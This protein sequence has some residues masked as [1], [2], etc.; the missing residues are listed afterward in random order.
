MTSLNKKKICFITG[1]RAEYGLIERMVEL[2]S[3]NN[4]FRTYLIVTG[5]HLSKKFGSTIK[6]ISKANINLKKIPIDLNLDSKK[7][8]YLNQKKL[9][10][11]IYKLS[12]KIKPTCFVVLGDRFE[13]FSLCSFIQFLNIPIVHIHGGEKTSGSLDDQLRHCITKMSHIH[14]VANKEFK[15][16]VLQL[17]EAKS[18]VYIVGGLG[19]DK[20]K[21]IKILNKAQIKKKINFREDKKNV[22]VTLHPDTLKDSNT[23][24]MTDAICK[25]IKKNQS[26]NFI[27]TYPNFDNGYEYI[28][29]KFKYLSKNKINVSFYKSLGDQMYLSLLKYCD[30]M[31]GNS[32]SGFTEAP[33]F[34]IPVL[35]IGDRQ[36]GRPISKN[37]INASISYSSINGKFINC[38]NKSHQMRK[39][40]FKNEYGKSGA[41]KRIYNVLKKYNFKKNLVK[42]NFNDF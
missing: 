2:F 20:I 32:S 29:K 30:V 36:N 34:K 19:L 4:S 18:S 21:R 17:G 27:L 14:F 37:I 11:E 12:E 25:I 1:S 41:S 33:Y 7:K 15:N 28:I 9:S 13:I 8:I 24:K 16:R 38:V 3:K 39:T 5:S 6:N 10:Q 35:N 42:K 31:M 26:I 23:K 40:R 22:L